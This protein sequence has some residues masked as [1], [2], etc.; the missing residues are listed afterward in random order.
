MKPILI[1]ALFGALYSWIS[2]WLAKHG[3]AIPL[4]GGSTG[5]LDPSLVQVGLNGFGA[6]LAHHGIKSLFHGAATPPDA[7]AAKGK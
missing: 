2:A 3:I 7:P 1:N 4:P 5:P 6:W